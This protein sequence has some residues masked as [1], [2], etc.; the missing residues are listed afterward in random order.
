MRFIYKIQGLIG[1]N[2][3]KAK[4]KKVICQP[5]KFMASLD[6]ERNIE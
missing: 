2:N 1:H 4:F 6:E 5:V 3:E